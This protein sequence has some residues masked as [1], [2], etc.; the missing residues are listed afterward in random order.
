VSGETPYNIS[1]ELNINGSFPTTTN[2]S[3]AFDYYDDWYAGGGW[4][5][6]SPGVLEGTIYFTSHV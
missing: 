4:G 5:G 3:T 1:R 2:F 6:P